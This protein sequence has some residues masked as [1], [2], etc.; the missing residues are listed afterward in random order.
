MTMTYELMK[1]IVENGANLSLEKSVSP[2]QLKELVEIAS[3]TKAHITIRTSLPQDLI[4]ELAAV[5]RN[6]V[7][8]VCAW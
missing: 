7:T 2:S 5:G 6:Q 3:Q 8:F 4:G 1:E